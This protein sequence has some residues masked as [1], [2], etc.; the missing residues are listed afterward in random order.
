M[1]YTAPLSEKKTKEPLEDFF[2]FITLYILTLSFLILTVILFSD[3]WDGKILWGVGSFITLFSVI[4]LRY[5]NMIKRSNEE[6]R[7][8]AKEKFSDRMKFWLKVEEVIQYSWLI[9][10]LILII[11]KWI[12]V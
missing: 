8:V 6:N 10:A 12:E 3:F 4:E 1:S 11:S 7:G 5:Y 9:G 2:S